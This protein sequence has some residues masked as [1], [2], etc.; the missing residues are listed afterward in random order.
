MSCRKDI[1][2][3][4]VNVMCQK[5]LSVSL[6]EWFELKSQLSDVNYVC[7]TADMWSVNQL[8]TVLIHTSVTCHVECRQHT[9]QSIHHATC[10]YK[11]QQKHK[12][13]LQTYLSNIV[14]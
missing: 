12:T 4:A 14:I 9:V 10:Q 6:D 5:T 8:L 13:Q 1:L 3:S 7:T 2:I 11:W